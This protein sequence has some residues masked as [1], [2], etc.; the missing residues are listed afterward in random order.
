MMHVRACVC[1]S[2]CVCV[3]GDDKGSKIKFT[4]S[5]VHISLAKQDK[6]NQVII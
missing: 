2:M 3:G 4:I 6:F 1:V 5:G